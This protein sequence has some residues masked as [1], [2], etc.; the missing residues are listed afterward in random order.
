MRLIQTGN[1]SCSYTV[2]VKASDPNGGSV[3][4]SLTINVTDELRASG[5]A[6][7]AKSDTATAGSGWSLEVTWSEP[8]NTGPPHHQLPNTVPQ[9]LGRPTGLRMALATIGN[10]TSVDRSAK[11]TTIPDDGQ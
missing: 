8:R 10:V 11:I 3:S 1:D 4:H 2:R 6:G 7:R 9:V 5:R